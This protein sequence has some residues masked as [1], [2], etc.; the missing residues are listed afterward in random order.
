MTRPQGFCLALALR[1]STRVISHRSTVSLGRFLR[2]GRSSDFP[3][4]AASVRAYSRHPSLCLHGTLF[5]P[6]LRGLGY[7][8]EEFSWSQYLRSTR[9]QAA[10]KHLF[11]S[12]T[13][14]SAP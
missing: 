2:G 8:E 4:S 12:Q 1:V 7:K 9:A 10:P 11:V 6:S 3:D 14:V 5:F 13:H